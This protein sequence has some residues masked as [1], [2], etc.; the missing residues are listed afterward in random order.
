MQKAASVQSHRDSE[1]NWQTAFPSDTLLR[2]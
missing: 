1:T 2:L